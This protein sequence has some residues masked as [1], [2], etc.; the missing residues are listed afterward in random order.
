MAWAKLG[1]ALDARIGF[2]APLRAALAK[3]FPSHWSFLLGEVALFSFVGL[4]LSGVYLALFYQPGIAP[5]VYEGAYRSF[6][7]RAM[8]QA[9]VSVLALSVDVP[10]GEVV[11]R[12][13]HFSAHLFVA[14]LLLHAARVFFTGA[15]RRPRELTWWI[16]IALFALALVNGF[17]GY[18][19]PFDMRG[20]SALRMMMTTLESVPWV[21]GWLATLI[22]GA[23]FPGEVV[24]G[25]LYIEHVFIGPIL[26]LAL[27]GAHLALVVRLS[28]TDY[29]APDRS[30]ALE[31]GARAWP[32]QAARSTTLVFLVFG[33]IALMSAFFPVEAVEAYGPFQPFTSY[34]PLTPDWYLMWIEGAY[35][36]LPR[37]L[38]FELIGATFTNPFYGAVVLPIAVFGGCV[39]YPAL[40]EW[41]YR[42]EV[43]SEHLL[44]SWRDRPFRTAFGASGLAFLALLSVGTLNGDIASA[45]HEEIRRVNIV[46]GIVTLSAPALVFASVFQRL[47]SRRARLVSR[48]APPAPAEEV[49]PVESHG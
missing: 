40:D 42:G 37:Q 29:P 25:R 39:I 11:R 26:I 18:C 22:V 43:R 8:P 2:R 28:H 6:A 5:V 19:L 16:G 15:F 14:S 34:P 31:V 35:R 44:E 3:L 9:F 21:G 27:I 49:R 33:V 45:F 7:G 41:I 24:I 32:D 4:V 48:P 47:R 10:F 46:L 23:T 38:D 1:R 13:H 36:M 17:T 12:F 30:D 20:G